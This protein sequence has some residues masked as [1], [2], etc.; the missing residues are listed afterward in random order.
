MT[1][2]EIVERAKEAEKRTGFGELV[3]S[4]ISKGVNSAYGI[5]F[6]EGMVEYRNSLQE[7]PASGKQ[8]KESLI[9]KHDDKT[10]KENGNSLTQETVS[11]ELDKAA[12]ED[13]KVVRSDDTEVGYNLDRYSGFI[14][15]AEWR[16]AQMMKKAVDGHATFEFYGIEGKAYGTIAHYPICLDDLGLKDT[17]KCKMI[18]IKE[19]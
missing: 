19:G 7:E 1:D 8:V 6:I 12:R 5:G 18:I 2:K 17:D 14:S 16:L 3:H 9:S 11:D 15:G 10:C 4:P 13:A